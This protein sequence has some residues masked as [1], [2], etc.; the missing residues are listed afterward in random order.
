M[1]RSLIALAAAV[2]ALATPAALSVA[3]EGIPGA[4]VRSESGKA[5]GDR[6]ARFEQWCRDNPEK[7]REEKARAQQ[8]REE[9]KA[10]PEKC[11]TEAQARRE[12]WCKDNPEKCRE[13]KARAQQRREECKANPEKCRAEAQA[14]SE[15]RFKRADANGDGRLSR[16]EAQKS[17][18]QVARDFDRI[19]ANKDG[20]VT[21]EELAAARKPRAGA[22]K[23]KGS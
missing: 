13:E 15:Q 18:P 17:M 20:Q 22:S 11:R 14:Q 6:K 9:C 2:A 10:N 3:S 19:D 12:Q 4:T 21:M 23:G 1:N 16:V 7:C 5:A 8:R